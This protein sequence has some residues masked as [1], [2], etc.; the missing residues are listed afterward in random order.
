MSSLSWFSNEEWW[1]R[2]STELDNSVGDSVVINKLV[3]E[4]GHNVT[5]L[6]TIVYVTDLELTL[7]GQSSV[8]GV[9]ACKTDQ[10]RYDSQT[11]NIFKNNTSAVR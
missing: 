5:R 10:P 2:D 9:K 1:K 11:M 8:L 6:R 7:F 4:Q 3:L